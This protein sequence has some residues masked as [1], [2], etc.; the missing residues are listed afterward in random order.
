MPIDVDSDIEGEDGGTSAL[1]DDGMETCDHVHTLAL[2]PA[3]AAGSRA[4]KR[5]RAPGG[6][7]KGRHGS[8]ECRINLSLRMHMGK[9]K[10]S[11]KRIAVRVL[12]S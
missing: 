9:A 4:P 12:T 3:A 11:V 8:Q 6:V 2:Q 10:K 1:L 7:G 5:S